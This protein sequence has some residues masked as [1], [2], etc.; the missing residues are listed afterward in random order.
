LNINIGRNSE[1]SNA[2]PTPPDSK[3]DDYV[4]IDLGPAKTISRQSATIYF[5]ADSGSWLLRVKGRNALRVNGGPLKRED[6]PHVLSSGEVVEIGGIEMMFVLPGEV[7][8]RIDDTFLQR[9]DTAPPVKPQRS[10]PP[11]ETRHALPAAPSSHP[12]ASKAQNNAARSGSFQQPIAPAPPDYKRPG[13]PPSAKSRGVGGPPSSAQHK[14]PA[15]GSSG[16]MVM[17]NNDSDLSLEENKHMKPLF[18]YA[19]MITQAIISTPEQKLSLN[20]IY[21]YIMN[22]YAYYRHQQPGG[23]QVGRRLIICP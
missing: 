15:F 20:H 1:P 2:H 21:N 16:T 23:W 19:Q 7:Q 18:S 12:S 9:L 11:A 13:T 22:N 3:S 8:L 17:H 4:H 14:S 6:D 5:D 10:S